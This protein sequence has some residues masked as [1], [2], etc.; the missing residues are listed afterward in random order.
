MK[1][2]FKFKEYINNKG[3]KRTISNFVILIIICIIGLIAWDTFTNEPLINSEKVQ[4]SLDNKQEA[5][6]QDYSD[7][8]E[9]QLETIL[10]QI[11]GVG[12]VDVMVT[13]E[14]STEV[15]PASNVTKSSQITEEKDSQG[16]IRTTTQEDLSENVVT[17]GG[18]QNLM[19]IKEIKPQIRGV[20]VVAQGA[21]DIRVKTELID[22]VRTI[23]QIPSYRVMVYEKN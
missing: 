23:F 5:W 19:V 15:I 18:N 9:T 20:V 17:S 8:M 12:A 22:A 2:L 11:K 6:K 1:I 3:Y 16:G 21:G 10:T 7:D 13:Y 14:S 4:E